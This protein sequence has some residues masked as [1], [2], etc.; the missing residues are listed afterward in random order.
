MAP[1]ESDTF[2]LA[3]PTIPSAPRKAD[4]LSKIAGSPRHLLWSPAWA[5][6]AGG[7]LNRTPRNVGSSALP[8]RKI[9]AHGIGTALVDEALY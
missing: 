1:A 4:Q 8:L 6:A 3:T 2:S 9:L 7:L 5:D